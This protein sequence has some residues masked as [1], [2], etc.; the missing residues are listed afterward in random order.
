MKNVKKPIQ[1]PSETNN[2]YLK[3]LLAN[4]GAHISAMGGRGWWMRGGIGDS[5]INGRR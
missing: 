5:Q 3:R 1:K 2:Q 4:A